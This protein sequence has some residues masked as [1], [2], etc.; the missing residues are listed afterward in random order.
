MGGLRGESRLP[1]RHGG[2]E[3]GR[4]FLGL[5]QQKGKE[6]EKGRKKAKREFSL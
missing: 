1:Q 4:E 5:K 6:V 2:T 3:G